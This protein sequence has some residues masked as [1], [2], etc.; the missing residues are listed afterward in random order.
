MADIKNESVIETQRQTLWEKY[1]KRCR[2]RGRE[3]FRERGKHTEWQGDRQEGIET[4][5]VKKVIF[6][7]K[8]RLEN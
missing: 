3:R 2:E 8:L 1:R 4:H 7:G 5:A 6:L